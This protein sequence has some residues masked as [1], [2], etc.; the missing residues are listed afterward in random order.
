MQRYIRIIS[1]GTVEFQSEACLNGLNDIQQSDLY[2]SSV[3]GTVA[4]MSAELYCEFSPVANKNYDELYALAESYGQ[5]LQVT[6][7]LLDYWNDWER[8][9]CWLPR[10]NFKFDGCKLAETKPGQKNSQFVK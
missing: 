2:C 10:D 6:N 7:N 8:R 1:E 3:A 9:A 5:G 4:E